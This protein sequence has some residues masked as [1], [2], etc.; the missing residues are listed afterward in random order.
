MTTGITLSH[1]TR[2][3]L[4]ITAWSNLLLNTDRCLLNKLKAEVEI[5]KMFQLIPTCTNDA[6]VSLQEASFLLSVVVIVQRKYVVGQ[7]YMTYVVCI[8]ILRDKSFFNASH[9]L[10]SNARKSCG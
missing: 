5:L 4:L 2:E 7:N 6:G 10:K 9:A 3:H 8:R 1:F